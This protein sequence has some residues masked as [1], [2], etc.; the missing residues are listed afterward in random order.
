MTEDDFNRLAAEAARRNQRSQP[1]EDPWESQSAPTVIQQPIAK[2]RPTAPATVQSQ[3]EQRQP[4]AI[5]P[6]LIGI[7]GIAAILAGCVGTF[8][9]LRADKGNAQPV[10]QTP[11]RQPSPIPSVAPS[12][13]PVPGIINP[14]AIQHVEPVAP[15]PTSGYPLAISTCNGVEA[16][17]NLRVSPG[18][19]IASILSHSAAFRILQQGEW[20]LIETTDGR[21]GYVNQCFIQ[22]ATAVVP[23]SIAPPPLPVP[24]NH[25]SI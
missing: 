18:G 3:P 4:S 19:A 16:D 22:G 6:V 8:A 5:A 23:K 24:N 13:V 17:A 12:P 21:Q 9:V 15:V 10:A 25:Q 20:S 7:I 14:P 2:P 11:E 1:V